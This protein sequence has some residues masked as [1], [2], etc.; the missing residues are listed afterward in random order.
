MA[1][2]TRENI[3][4]LN[5]KI[6]I[7][8]S[9]DDYSSSFEKSLKGFA[10][11]ANISGFRKGMVPAGVVK[12][13][14]GQGV[15]HDEV[16]RSVEKELQNYVSQEQLE[17]FAQPLPLPVE[18]R[19]LDMNNP[20]DYAFAFEIGLRPAVDINVAGITVTKYKVQ[21]TD[22]MIA[23]ETNRLQTRHGKLVDRPEISNDEELI[24][25]SFSAADADGNIDEAGTKKDNSLLVKY[26]APAVRAQLTGKKTGDI[27]LVQPGTAFDE[28]EREWVMQDLGLDKNAAEDANKY[29]S[30]LITKV[31]FV[32]KA[33][34]AEEFF[35]AAFP[36]R[37][38]ASEEEFTNAVKVDIENYY[39]G[40]SRSQLHDQVYHHLVDH[41][42]ID[43]PEGFLK[44][45]IQMSGEKEMTA[46]EAEQEYPK[47]ADGLKWSLISTSLLTKNKITVDP[48]EIKQFARNQVS[49]YMGIQNMEEAP[50]LD[51]YANRMMQDKKFIENTYQQLQ[52]D[53]LFN[54]LETEVNIKEE[55]ITIEGLASKMH[56]H[57][58]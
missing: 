48:E 8:V 50:W 30:L 2:I 40:Q 32:E 15:F 21:V 52:T 56:H 3:G 42:K 45:W 19:M 46:Q 11:T 27:I 31:G 16:I 38:I 34:M 22:E 10:K 14:Y 44:R 24:N 51:E 25:V 43:F 9:K 5:D 7:T 53:K 36:G 17:I 49:G 55:E 41:T 6:T 4:L 37:S 20:G 33:A 54:L 18:E 1:T 28:K 47:F 39:N 26:F 13:M 57:H 23:D 29:F 35:N 58:H 12:K